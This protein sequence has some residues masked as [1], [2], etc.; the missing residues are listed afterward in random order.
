MS[1]NSVDNRMP[2]A[3]CQVGR[4][5][6]A[7]GVRRRG[8]PAHAGAPATRPARGWPSC[9]GPPVPPGIPG[10]PAHTGTGL[11]RQSGRARCHLPNLAPAT[12]GAGRFV[13]APASDGDPAH[14]G[15]E[16]PAV[17]TGRFRNCPG[18][19]EGLGR[20]LGAGTDRNPEPSGHQG[21]APCAL[22]RPDRSR[23]RS[24][25]GCRRSG[26]ARGVTGGR[27]AGHRGNAL[28]RPGQDRPPGAA[29]SNPGVAA[30]AEQ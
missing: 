16:S 28:P 20:R 14:D 18:M 17:G 23:A 29:G 12:A 21:G 15:R 5:P 26:R 9:C 3:S 8:V 1:T 11:N 24:R 6:L 10:S 2:R 22:R 25:A 19:R 4:S 30:A 13:A 7:P 27:A